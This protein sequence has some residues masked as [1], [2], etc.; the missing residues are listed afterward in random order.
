MTDSSKLWRMTRI[1]KNTANQ[2]SPHIARIETQGSI[3][4]EDRDVAGVIRAFLSPIRDADLDDIEGYS[5]PDPIR[6]HG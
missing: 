2:R 4:A 5:Y 1:L 3:I 6:C